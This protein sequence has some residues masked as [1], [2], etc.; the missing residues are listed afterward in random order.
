MFGSIRIGRAYSKKQNIAFC[1][2]HGWHDWYLA[3]NLQN[4]KN[5]DDQLLQ[6]LRQRSIKVLQG[7]SNLYLQ[8]YKFIKKNF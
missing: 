7:L 6:D 5:L 2:Y 1:G 8:R 4:S 3:A